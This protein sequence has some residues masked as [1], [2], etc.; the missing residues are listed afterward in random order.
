MATFKH[1]L[2]AAL[3]LICS[4]AQ[5]GDWA[6]WRGTHRNGVAA[7]SPKLVD[8]LPADGLKPV[9]V[10]EK[11]GSGKNDGGWGSPVVV[12]FSTAAKADRRVYLFT[13]KRVKLRDV[14][15][16]KF[17]WLP[18]EKRVGMTPQEYDKYEADRRNEDEFIAKSYAFRESIYCMNAADGKTIWK[19]E[20]DSS[21]SRFPQSGSPTVVDGRLYILGAGR[22]VRCLDARSGDDVW[23]VRLPGEFRDEFW[24][25]S[26]AVVDGVAVFL[27]GHLIAVDL[28]TGKI[29][30]QGDAKKTRGTHSS[31]VVWNHDGQDLI[32][33]NVAGSETICIEPASGKELWRIKSEAGLATPVIQDDLLITYNNSRKKGMRCFRM[34]L[35]GAEEIWKYQGCQDKGSSPVV[36]NGHV[37]VQGEKRLACVDLASGEEEWM[38]NLDLGRPQYTSLVAADSKV[39]YALEGMLCFEATDS[40]FKPLIQGKIDLN[41]LLATEASHRTRLKL[42]ALPQNK[43]EKEYQSQVGRHGPVACAS[44]AIADGRMF[45]RLKNGIACY[46]LRSKK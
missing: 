22:H 28:K 11:I 34:K 7:D 1:F 42:D 2:C 32:V 38:T 18:P 44:P 39:Y 16:K 29:K 45:V 9:W 40:D 31:P 3:V 15:K 17:P 19:N 26:F 33:V 5:A 20:E 14:P 24:D 12:D 21:Y 36:V 43:A 41:G 10:S 4:T 37:Y 35:D 30:W 8:S 23:N 6:Q 13:H 27:A 25:S 46:D